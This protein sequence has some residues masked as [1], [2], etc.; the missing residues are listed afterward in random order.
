MTPQRTNYAGG[1]FITTL[2]AIVLVWC[3]AI[4]APSQSASSG[5][6]SGAALFVEQIYPLLEK[7]CLNCHKGETAISGLDL[8]T[9]EGLLKGGSRGPAIVLPPPP[10]RPDR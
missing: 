6:E 8:S 9:R 1:G 5:Q 4:P 2:A 7:Q 3:W 10:M